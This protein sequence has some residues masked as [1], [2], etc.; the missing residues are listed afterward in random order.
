MITVACSSAP[1]PIVPHSSVFLSFSALVTKSSLGDC[2]LSTL[3]WLPLLL[4]FLNRSRRRLLIVSISAIT[5]RLR[6]AI[7]LDGFPRYTAINKLTRQ[8]TWGIGRGQTLRCDGGTG[9]RFGNIDERLHE[10]RR[11]SRFLAGNSL[12]DFTEGYDIYVS[13]I[14]FGFHL[15]HTPSDDVQRGYL[16]WNM[17]LLSRSG[18]K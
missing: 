18:V 10:Y 2:S 17:I 16:I 14:T 5:S 11:T 4:L 3:A 12:T 6:D 1:R 15:H 7:P 9:P 13:C 8:D